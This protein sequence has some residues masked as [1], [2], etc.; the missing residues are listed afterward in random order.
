MRAISEFGLATAFPEGREE[1]T[2]AELAARTGLP[3]NHLQRFLRHAMTYHIFREPQKGVVCHTAASKLLADDPLM[4]QW[5]S[6][7]SEELWP[8]ATKVKR[9]P[10]I[11]MC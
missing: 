9:N 11:S 5:V 1:T 6:M 3:E 8:A 4:R 7:V 10:A 2:Y